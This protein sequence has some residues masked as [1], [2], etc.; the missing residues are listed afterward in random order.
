MGLGTRQLSAARLVFSMVSILVMSYRSKHIEAQAGR[1]VEGKTMWLSYND[2]LLRFSR[3]SSHFP[4]LM[5]QVTEL[6][7]TT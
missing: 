4:V 6:G 3:K 5:G 1:T 7:H 2:L